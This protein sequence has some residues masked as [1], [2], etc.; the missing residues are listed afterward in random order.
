MYVPW[1]T[2]NS[3]TPRQIKKMNVPLTA[4]LDKYEASPEDW[5][6]AVVDEVLAD[7]NAGSS[8]GTCCAGDE[9]DWLLSDAF[10]VWV[11]EGE[12]PSGWCSGHMAKADP[13]AVPSRSILKFI[14]LANSP[15]PDAARSGN[16]DSHPSLTRRTT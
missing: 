13:E 11:L 12:K 2:T 16:E 9:T 10:I 15:R 6:G 14:F 5:N 3:K 1:I 4:I 8:L 7:V